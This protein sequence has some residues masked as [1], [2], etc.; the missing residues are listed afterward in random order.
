MEAICSSE[1]PADFQRITQCHIPEDSTPHNHRCENLKSLLD[2]IF[3][4]R[5]RPKPPYWRYCWTHKGLFFGKV[6]YSMHGVPSEALQTDYM[7]SPLFLSYAIREGVDNYVIFETFNVSRIS[8]W[9]KKK[10][11]YLPEI[12]FITDK[13]S[14]TADNESNTFQIHGN[15]PQIHET[16]IS[17]C[18]QRRRDNP[19]PMH[20]AFSDIVYLRYSF[21][22]DWTRLLRGQ[23]M[24]YTITS[25]PKV[26]RF[27]FQQTFG[28][29]AL[30]GKRKGC[31]LSG[32]SPA[33]IADSS[34]VATMARK[35]N[36]LNLREINRNNTHTALASVLNYY[37]WVSLIF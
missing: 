36:V 14:F 8:S 3:N 27:Y 35:H 15:Y 6:G 22:S 34:H 5:W 33:P 12:Y 1:T 30:V 32:S 2:S 23:L 4:V 26:T 9:T 24:T 31:Y 29:H 10:A 20:R 21:A 37:G 16:I 18:C 13:H 28:I 19:G 7:I 17:L 25:S 11:L